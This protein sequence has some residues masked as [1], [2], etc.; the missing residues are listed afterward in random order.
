GFTVV[1]H[2]ELV[3]GSKE[4]EVVETN[5]DRFRTKFGITN[6]PCHPEL[7]SGSKGTEVGEIVENRFQLKEDRVTRLVPRL[8]PLSTKFGMTISPL[9]LGEGGRSPGE[10]ICISRKFAFTLAEVLITLGIIGVVA[11]LT[12]PTLNQA[13]NKRVRAEQIRTVKYKFTKATDKMNSLGLIGPYNSTAAFVA[14]LQKHLKIAKVCPSS[15]LRECWPYDKITLLD[16]K[17]YE[18]TKIQTGKQFQMKNSDTADYSSPNVGIITGDGTPM[19]LSYNTK[20]EALDPVK[21]YGWS[22]ED[23]KPV[24]NATASCVAAVF[25][26]NG[27]GKPNKQNDDVALFNANGLGNSCAIELDGGKCFGA[28]FTPK[29][30]TL[31]ECKQ[32]KA[33]GMVNGCHYEADYWAGA[34][35]Q[36]GGK[37]NMPTM[38]DLGKIASAIYEGNPSI[39]AKQDVS[40]LTYKPGT[41]TSLGLPEPSFYLWSGEESNSGYAYYRNFYPTYSLWSYSNRGDS[42]FQAVCLGD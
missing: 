5:K 41:A 27:T 17:E 16:G 23:N 14:E 3:S 25:E 35:K 22:T 12:L 6:T 4:A 7:V 38:A 15:K 30:V 1:S 11:A 32:M 33:D 13:V 37:G 29:P 2:P 39:G 26:I 21:Q 31:A 19:I 42:H 9:P 28:P 8:F 40:G 20:C 34:V 18:V 36:C 10:G 24:S